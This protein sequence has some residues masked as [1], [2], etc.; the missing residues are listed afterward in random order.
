MCMFDV[1]EVQSAW[2]HGLERMCV[3][4]AILSSEGS[5]WERLQVFTNSEERL[6]P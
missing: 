2:I 4:S 3:A 6:S 5:L 1:G